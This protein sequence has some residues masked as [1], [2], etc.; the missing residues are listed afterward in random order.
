MPCAQED[1]EDTKEDSEK[2]HLSISQFSMGS[3]PS[4]VQKQEGKG[5]VIF[6]K[7][8]GE[9]KFCASMLAMQALTSL[10]CFHQPA[11]WQV[12]VIV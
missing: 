10:V 12:L 4:E 5:I 6:R 8:D 11:V 1:S 3:A 2:Q 9:S 7:V